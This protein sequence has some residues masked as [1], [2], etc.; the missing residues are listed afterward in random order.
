MYKDL[1]FTLKFFLIFAVFLG[2]FISA[3]GKIFPYNFIAPFVASYGQYFAALDIEGQNNEWRW[4]AE[5]DLPK[6]MTLNSVEKAQQDYIAYTST[7]DTTIRL[8]DPSGAAAFSWRLDV[9]ALWPNQEH[10]NTVKKVPFDYF[11]LRD[12]HIFPD[13]RALMIVSMYGSTPWGAGLVMLDKNSNVLWAQQGYYYNDLHVDKA[14]HI[15]ALRH[16][17]TSESDAG[18]FDEAVSFNA[19][20]LQDL[21]VQLNQQG[22]I[23]EELAVVDMLRKSLYK[24]LVP[25]IHDDGKG[26]YTHTNAIDV[27][28]IGTDT[29]D[30]LDAGDI[31]ASLRNLDVL[32]AIDGQTKEIKWAAHMPVK[33]QHDIDVLPN[34][35]FLLYDNQG[36]LGPE[37][38]SR[39][40][41]LD[42]ETLGVEWSYVG[43]RLMPF[44]SEFWGFQQRLDNGNTLTTVPNKGHL[45][46]VTPAGE[47]VMSYY[48][49]YRKL[50]DGVSYNPVLT[51]ASK[52]KRSE[53]AFLDNPEQE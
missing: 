16:E 42:P 12:F 35:N 27:I 4:Y 37:G 18:K 40:V 48:V 50:E 10:I 13:G 20:Y 34:G 9:E 3:Y 28:E 1:I 5:E 29:P 39:L 14:G 2:G 26:D 36:H 22:E 53:L 38:Y 45:F 24:N 52:I 6:G 41:E 33:M 7:A 31:M 19:P 17:I 15:Y 32:V 21:I 49:P 47:V 8:L 44:E 30:F 43:S 51:S 25:Y 11:T 23:V 46:E